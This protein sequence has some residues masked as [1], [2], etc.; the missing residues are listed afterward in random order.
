M[1]IDPALGR[2]YTATMGSARPHWGDK[3]GAGVADK[4]KTDKLCKVIN[5]LNKDFKSCP[6][7]GIPQPYTSPPP[8]DKKARAELAFRQTKAYNRGMMVAENPY[9]LYV[10]V[11]WV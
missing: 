3:Y 4:E 9:S 8:P 10:Y 5:E 1:L 2:V 7:I 11:S 6:S